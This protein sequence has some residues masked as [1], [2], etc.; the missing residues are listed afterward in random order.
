M[1][2]FP[3]KFKFHLLMDHSYPGNL[4]F[5]ELCIFYKQANKSEIDEM[6][7]IVERGDWEDFKVLIYQ[8]IGVKLQ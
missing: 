7:D 3:S 5:Q 4:G 2:A 8:V 1:S 6:E